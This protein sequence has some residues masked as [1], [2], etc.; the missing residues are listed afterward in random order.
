MRSLIF[1]STPRKGHFTRACRG[2]VCIAGLASAAV[3]AQ[4]S[5]STMAPT[6]ADPIDD[7]TG[8]QAHASPLVTPSALAPTL[9]QHPSA[10][11]SGLGAETQAAQRVL[12]TRWVA[13]SAQSARS[14][15]TSWAN[16]AGWSLVWDAHTD[17]PRAT[18]LEVS[19]SFVTALQGFNAAAGAHTRTYPLRIEAFTRQKIVHVTDRKTL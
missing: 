18:T 13:S 1:K 12:P 2:L 9:T 7:V 3:H 10:T 15:L 14:V 11:T 5:R 4:S 19:G 16:L 17:G 6:W 8:Q